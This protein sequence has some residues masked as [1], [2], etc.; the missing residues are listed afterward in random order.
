MNHNLV[1]GKV[2]SFPMQFYTLFRKIVDDGIDN[3]LSINVENVFTKQTKL[4]KS[5]CKMSIV[6]AHNWH[7]IQVNRCRWKILKRN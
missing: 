3:T 1:A 5:D 4:I 6:S 7:F 2:F